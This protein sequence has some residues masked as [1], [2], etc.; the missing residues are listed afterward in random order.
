M[1]ADTFQKRNY[2]N[3]EFFRQIVEIRKPPAREKNLSAARLESFDH[4]PNVFA[5]YVS[6]NS[7]RCIIAT[8]LNNDDLRLK[9]KRACEATHGLRRGAARHALVDDAVVVAAVFQ[10]PF[11]LGGISRLSLHTVARRHAVTDCKN[12]RPMIVGLEEQQQKRN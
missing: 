2:L 10:F 5:R 9:G 8:E 4:E 6:R 11:E 1:S 12:H 7:L 3:T